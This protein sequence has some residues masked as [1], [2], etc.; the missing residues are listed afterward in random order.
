ML[1]GAL[2]VSLNIVM[3]SSD[4]TLS[5]HS[6]RARMGVAFL[7]GWLI[8]EDLA[9]EHLVKMPSRGPPLLGELQAVYTSRRQLPPKLR[10]F[11]DFLRMRLGARV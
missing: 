8:G 6:L 3:K 9:A 11:I 10:S 4:T 7:P 5:Y 2:P 1:I